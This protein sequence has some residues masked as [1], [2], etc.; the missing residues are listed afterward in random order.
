MGLKIL[1][2]NFAAVA[3]FGFSR[4]Y[5][6]GTGRGYGSGMGS[7]YGSSYGMGGGYGYGSGEEKD[8][9]LKEIDNGDS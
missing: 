2:G 5:A 3:K 4:G 7:G 1:K 6:R 9:G 8:N